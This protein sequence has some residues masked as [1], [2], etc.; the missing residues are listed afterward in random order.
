VKVLSTLNEAQARGFVADQ[1]LDLGHGGV[2]R[3]SQITA[4][5]WMTIIRM[6]KELRYDP[7]SC[8]GRVITE[9]LW[10]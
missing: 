2:S 4:M 7:C 10:A 1:A 8:A 5:S 9:D 6:M 3:L